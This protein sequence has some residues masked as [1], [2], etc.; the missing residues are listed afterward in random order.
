MKIQTLLIIAATSLAS[1]APVNA[2]PILF[3]DTFN[4]VDLLMQS[5]AGTCVESSSTPDSI[6]GV[7]SGG[8]TTLSFTHTLI[9]FDSTT[10]VLDEAQL[11]LRF[12]DDSDAQA[13]KFDYLFDSLAGNN[14]TVTSASLIGN[15]FVFSLNVLSELGDGQLNILLSRT[16]GDFRF[17]EA[18]LT[19]RGNRAD[20]EVPP[21]PEPATLLLFSGGMFAVSRRLRRRT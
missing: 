1:A 9:G 18:A 6:V 5:S 15:P 10:D 16:V 8:C 19:V 11:T 2:E 14:I 7:A 21:V 3:T 4:P 20:P 13:E 12:Y 17:A